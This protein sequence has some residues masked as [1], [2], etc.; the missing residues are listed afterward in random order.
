MQRG[1]FLGTTYKLYGISWGRFLLDSAATLYV[2]QLFGY[3]RYYV[4]Q[5]ERSA[6]GH[7]T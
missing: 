7:T 5:L 4:N 2:R 1:S 3:A 6:A